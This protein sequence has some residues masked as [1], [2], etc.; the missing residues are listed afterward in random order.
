MRLRHFLRDCS[1][2]MAILFALGFSAAATMSVLV[3]DTA[4]LYG[5]RRQLQAA[6]DLAAIYAVADTSR[7]EARAQASLADAGLLVPG[8]RDG[9]TVTTGNYDPTEPVIAARFQPGRLP[10]NAVRVVLQRKGTLHFSAQILGAP[11]L[12]ASGIAAVTPE[13]SF[14]VGSR[15]ASLNGGIANALLSK[16]TGTTVNLS[17]LDYNALAAARIDAFA[18][19]DALATQLNV[20]AGSYNDVL[21]A[22]ARSGTIAAALATLTTGSTRTALQNLTLAGRGNKVP[23]AEL[24]SL[25]DLGKLA[26]GSEG[27]MA[28]LSLSAMEVLSAAA[29]LADGDRQASLVLGAN[30]PGL[31]SLGLD[32]AIGQPPQ[33]SG[34]FAI[35]PVG[36]VLRTAQVRLRLR[37]KL[38]GGPVL[39]GAAVNLPLWLD[40][41]S[42]EARVVSATCPTETSAGTARIEVLPGGT[43]MA[44]GELADSV[45]RNFGTAPAVGSVRLIDLLLLRVTGS[46]QIEAK[47][48]T[49]LRLDFTSAEI[50][51]GAVKTARSQTMATAL[52]Q[53]L[54]SGMTIE[55]DVLGLGLSPSSVIAQAVRALIMPLAPTLDMTINA[56]LATLGLGVGEADIR[57]YGV[58]CHKAV[59]VG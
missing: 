5:E 8:S 36:T 38:L 45:F 9:L 1:G 22:E 33:G 7:A 4:S 14:S 15:L 42:A 20:T 40:L 34:W 26:L 37:A 13:V 54:L 19:L 53:S 6:V 28:G 31:V 16:L 18:F 23:L 11:T 2:N 58:R 3:I 51:Q 57:V 43:T 50:T 30:V 48:T 25:G 49:P 10:A 29:A 39:L 46:A 35:G 21:A 41:A 59:L 32:L 12:G 55:V 17:V 56:A 27:A 24:F 47:Q 52:A 44:L